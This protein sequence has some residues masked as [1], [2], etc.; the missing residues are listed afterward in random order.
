MGEQHEPPRTPV[1]NDQSS[2]VDSPVSA[3]EYKVRSSRLLKVINW[4]HLLTVYLPTIQYAL[5][6]LLVAQLA[7][8]VSDYNTQFKVCNEIEHDTAACVRHM[9]I[10]LSSYPPTHS[11]TLPG[12]SAS[13][14][15]CQDHHHL[16][17][18]EN[19]TTLHLSYMVR[20]PHLLLPP[21]SF[22]MHACVH[23]GHRY[24]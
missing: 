9:S 7:K 10:L 2:S 12:H 6:A 8:D 23:V 21:P 22:H 3:K 24:D 1:S 5:V 13:A 14:R 17:G 20:A 4:W 15:R 19:H 18:L 16:I 11:Y